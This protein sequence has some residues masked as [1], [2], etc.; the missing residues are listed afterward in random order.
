MCFLAI[1]NQIPFFK[2]VHEILVLIVMQATKAQR[3]LHKGAANHCLHCLHI[4]SMDVNE[5]SN[6]NLDQALLDMSG[7]TFKGGFTK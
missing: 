2:P 5:D 6:Q 1:E 3:S 7:W 4:Q